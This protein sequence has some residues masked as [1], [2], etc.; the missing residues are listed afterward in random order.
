MAPIQILE[1]LPYPLP[2]GLIWYRPIARIE[3]FPLNKY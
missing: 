1:E 3:Y 2:I